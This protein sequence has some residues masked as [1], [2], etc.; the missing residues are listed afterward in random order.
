M[1]AILVADYSFTP[2]DYWRHVSKTARQFISRCLTIDPVERMTAH[3][4]LAHPW[5]TGEGEGGPGEPGK[6]DLLPTVKKNFNARRT[7]HA[8]IDTI[9]AINQL[10]AG[11]AAAMNAPASRQAPAGHGKYSK[12]DGEAMDGVVPAEKSRVAEQVGLMPEKEHVSQGLRQLEMDPRGHGRG[13]TEEM[14]REQHRRVQET[15]KGLWEKAV[16]SR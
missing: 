3:Q 11:G 7:L 4:A 2:L 1:Q 14:I 6:V 15:S 5:I 8:A 13:Q 12:A 16:A 10:R 9:R